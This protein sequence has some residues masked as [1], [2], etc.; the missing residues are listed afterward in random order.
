MCL[1]AANCRGAPSAVG[2]LGGSLPRS[3]GIKGEK[4]EQ[5]AHC[6]ADTLNS[7]DGA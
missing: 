2:V 6:A 1:L 4:A 7:G 5:E 3:R